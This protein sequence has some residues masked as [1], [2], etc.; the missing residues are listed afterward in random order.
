MKEHN[1]K[2]TPATDTAPNDDDDDD[3]D[4]DELTDIIYLLYCLD[5]FVLRWR[6][7]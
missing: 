3:D 5:G 1:T 2:Y 6:M 7:S 4:D